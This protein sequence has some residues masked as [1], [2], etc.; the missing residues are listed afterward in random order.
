MTHV[1]HDP[2]RRRFVAALESADGAEAV[3]DYREVGQGTLDYHHTYVP[4]QHRGKGVAG[5]LARAA[6]DHARDQ[7]VKVIPSC[8]YVRRFIDRHREYQDLVARR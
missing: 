1:A 6:L 7:G 2:D 8:W 3:L 5:E 4:D